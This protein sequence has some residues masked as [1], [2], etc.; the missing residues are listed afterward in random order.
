MNITYLLTFLAALFAGF[1]Y[2]WHKLRHATRNTQH[3]PPRPRRHKGFHRTWRSAHPPAAPLIR[4]LTE[5]RTA[6]AVLFLFLLS[7]FCFPL[8]LP[9]AEYGVAKTIWSMTVGTN[10]AAVDTSGTNGNATALSPTFGTNLSA[11][12]VDCTKNTEFTLDVQIYQTNASAGSFNIPWETS[13]D[14]SHWGGTN[15]PF[16][17]GVF[18]IPLTNSTFSASGTSIYW[19][20]NFPIN[21]VG[22]FRILYGT[23]LGSAQITQA[24]V[25]AYTKPARVNTF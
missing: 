1:L 11:N 20:T 22:Y 21:S 14:N 12:V 19:R 25:R 8:C 15:N 3:A 9:A 13:A 5:H 7:A 2:A 18:N 4:W 24:V 6:A 23:N 10:V 16:C 17:A